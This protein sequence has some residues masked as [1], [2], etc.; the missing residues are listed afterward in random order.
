MTTEEYK[1]SVCGKALTKALE[2]RLI[3]MDRPKL[4]CTD[5]IKAAYKPLKESIKKLLKGHQR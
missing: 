5:C 4:I 3:R 2:G 1:C